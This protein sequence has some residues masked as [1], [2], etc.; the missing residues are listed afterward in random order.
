[1]KKNLF[2]LMMMI[3]TSVGFTTSCKD[4][5]DDDN[6]TADIV[7]EEPADG[8]SVA[9]GDTLMIHAQVTGS[10]AMHGW[11]LAVRK[12]TEQTVLYSTD[13]HD[14]AATY[15]IHG[16]W[17]NT[18]PAGTQMEIVVTV[19]LNHDGATAVKTATFTSQP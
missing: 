17:V 19:T 13:A 8:A 4:K 11:E 5:E 15:H 1:M 9:Q 3:A 6:V 2:I 10:A 14:H 16:E 18:M 12:K 7:I